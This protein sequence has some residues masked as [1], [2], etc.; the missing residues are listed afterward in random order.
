MKLKKF[1]AVAAIVAMTAVSVVSC[2]IKKKELREE[3][4]QKQNGMQV[5][6]S[7]SYPEKMVPEQ[8][9]LSSNYS[10]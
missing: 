4:N 9:A 5:M 1:L 6:T 2:G 8:E 10:G 7:P 3:Q